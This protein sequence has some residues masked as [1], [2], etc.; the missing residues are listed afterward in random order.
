MLRRLA[1]LLPA[2]PATRALIYATLAGS[3]GRALFI[4]VSVVFFT[5]SVGL[6]AAEVGLGLTIAAVLGLFVGV[7]AGHLADRVGP[8]ATTVSFGLARAGMP[9]GYLLVD[10]F[11]GFLVVAIVIAMLEAAGGA[12]HGALVAG[13]VP[14]RDRVRTRA[15]LRSAT[16][17]GWAFGA[18]GAGVA[19]HFDTRFAYAVLLFVCAGCALLAS[20]LNL[21]VPAVA[22]RPKTHGGPALIALRDR[23][24]LTLTVLNAVLCVHYG[25]LNVAVPLWVV[26]RTEAPAW[27]VGGLGLLNAVAV[28]LFQVR[29]SRGSGDATGAAAAQRVSGFLLAGACVLYALAEGQPM[30]VAAAVLVIAA[31][32]HVLGELRQ[33]AG[34]WG[35]SF[36]LAPD[37]AQ[38]Q[39]QGLYGTGFSMANVVA[40]ALLTTVV[41]GWGWPGWALFAVAFVVTGLAVPIAARWA[42]RTR[43]PRHETAASLAGAV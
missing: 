34:S 18:V 41:V 16:N 8:R 24:F 38:G 5:R 32:V 15:I 17:V 29:A 40:P 42:L 26:Q 10:D 12:S 7:P 39:Y 14:A 30:W 22:P 31:L 6:S 43:S 25:M 35:L 3:T 23:P 36:D 19:L 27:I 37:H 33:A 9:L 28:I 11:A 13:A 20:L 2:H 1:G 4:T 21:R